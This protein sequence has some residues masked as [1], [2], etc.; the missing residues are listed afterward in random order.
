ML[1]YMYQTV[2]GCSPWVL[3]KNQD[4]FGLDAEHFNPD[5]WLK[6]D[7]P[8]MRMCRLG[9]PNRLCLKSYTERHILTFGQGSRGCIG[10][11]RSH[12]T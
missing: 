3:H 1:A 11:S 2:V 10:R 12:T 4:I 8:A 9:G 5:R 7:V 6:G